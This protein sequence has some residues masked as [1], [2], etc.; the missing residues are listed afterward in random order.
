M[1]RFVIY[2]FLYLTYCVDKQLFTAV[3]EKSFKKWMMGTTAGT[4]F[5]YL[6]YKFKLGYN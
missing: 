6:L 4:R 1:R 3:K 5:K 2:N